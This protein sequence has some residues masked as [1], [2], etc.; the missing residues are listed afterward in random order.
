[1]TDDEHLY[2]AFFA[3]LRTDR[4]SLTE[5]RGDSMEPTLRSGD[6]ILVDLSDTN[7]SIPG[8]CALRNGA[9]KRVERVPGSNRVRLT[10]DNDRHGTYE[11]PAETVKVL[12]R[13]VWFGRR[14]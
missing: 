1:M 12:G 11:V 13:V 2:E 8:V 14:L 6:Q 10:S 7:I 9:I 4:L 3:P 5:V